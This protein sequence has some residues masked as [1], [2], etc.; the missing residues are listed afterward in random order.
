MSGAAEAQKPQTLDELM[1]AMDV[2][3]TIRHSELVVER[4]LSQGDRD[5]ALKQR[6]RNIYQGQGIAVSDATIEQGIKALKEQRFAYSPPGPSFGRSLAMLWIR[7]VT[8]G[9]WIGAIAIAA[10]ALSGI[11]YFGFVVPR[12]QA[13]QEMQA[14][15]SDRLPK[16][17][18]QIAGAARVE[19]KDPAVL[20]QIDGAVRDGQ[21]A[22]ARGDVERA[23][24][25]VGTLGALR[26]R[27]VQV[28]DLKVISRSGVSSGVWRESR[29]S[30]GAR[31]YYLIVQAVTPEGEVLSLP[32][33]SEETGK[34]SV[35]E[36]W[37]VRVPEA[38]YEMIKADKLDNGI[39]EQ[40]RIAHKAR[41][42]VEPRYEFSKE[43]GAITSWDE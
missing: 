19:T 18:L 36:T 20:A 8:Y 14:D 39:V 11:N 41:G 35:V 27:L 38:F 43:G 9:R 34:S 13:L 22:L 30:A 5:A 25:A 29:T 26:D 23:R 15:L 4:E 21:A 28:Y 40:D 3:D 12:E 1:L 31:N 32:I 42:Q 10:L 2:V 37:G 33:T 16:Q 7:R 6:L 24:G 17:L